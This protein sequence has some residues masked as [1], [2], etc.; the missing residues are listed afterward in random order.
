[1][2]SVVFLGSR[3][4]PELEPKIH[5]AL[6]VA[7]ATVTKILT[8]TQ[9]SQRGQNSHNAALPKYNSAPLRS[10]CPLLHLPSPY[11]LICHCFLLYYQPTSGGHAVAHYK[12]EDRG[13]D[14]RLSLNRNE[15]REYF[16]GVK[17]A[18]A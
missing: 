5:V 10:T 11:L 8:K 7:Q 9:P 18:G 12:P 3:T 4:N 6:H 17:A 14:S 16:V 1:M 13:F 15:Y 2:F